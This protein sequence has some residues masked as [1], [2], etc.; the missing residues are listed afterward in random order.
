M[1]WT[2]LDA[3]QTMWQSTVSPQSTWSAKAN[4]LENWEVKP[5]PSVTVQGLPK[6]NFLSVTDDG[7][8]PVDITSVLIKGKH[9]TTEVPVMVDADG[10]LVLSAGVTINAEGLVVDL[11][12]IKQGPAGTQPW[13]VQLSG[14]KARIGASPA[15]GAKTVT[16]TAA[17][18]F[19]GA[20]RKSGR[21]RLEI[22]NRHSALTIRVG[23][24]GVT[25]TTGRSVGPGATLTLDLDPTADVPIYAI[26]EAG[27]VPVEVFEA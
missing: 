9:G 12:Q 3:P 5:M 24:A 4:G 15:T 14:S 25:D 11:G 13:P 23:P 10:K 8:V 16:A 22:A 19:A 2:A 6:G 27:A 7:K 20:S 1:G 18:V 17:E 26:S 21:S